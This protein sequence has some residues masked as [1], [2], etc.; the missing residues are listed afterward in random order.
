MA[1]TDSAIKSFRNSTPSTV[2]LADEKG[3]FLLITASG[4]KLW[5][6]RYR[7][8]NREQLLALG[9]YPGVSLEEAR[10]R[11][12]EIRRQAAAVIDRLPIEALTCQ[13]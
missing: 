1:L 6:A 3:L 10:L 7:F 9:A 4:A 13:Q 12:D 11:R 2:K 5:R 8:A